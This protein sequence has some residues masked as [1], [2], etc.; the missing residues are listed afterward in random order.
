MGCADADMVMQC[1]GSSQCL[2]GSELQTGA[3]EELAASDSDGGTRQKGQTPMN[4]DEL[5]G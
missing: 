4:P 2:D 5:C 1:Q 3:T